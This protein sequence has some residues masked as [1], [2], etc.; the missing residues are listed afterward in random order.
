MHFS[1]SDSDAKSS[2]Y[3]ALPLIMTNLLE[4]IYYSDYYVPFVQRIIDIRKES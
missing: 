1:F 4:T 3:T 2:R